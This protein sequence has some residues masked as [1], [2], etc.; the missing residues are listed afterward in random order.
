[1]S[2][3]Q[4]SRQ[5]SVLELHRLRKTFKVGRGPK[6]RKVRAVDDVSLTLDKGTTLAVVGES[7]SGKTTLARLAMSLLPPDDGD[8]LLNGRN[9]TGLSPRALA[10][11]RPSMQ[12]VFQDPFDSLAPWHTAEQIVGSS[13]HLR[14]DLG[15]AERRRL[16]VEVLE[17]VGLPQRFLSRY[18]HELSGGQAQRVG[19]ARAIVTRP[20]LVVLDEPT[21]ALD[22]SV[23]AQILALLHEL[24]NEEQLSYLFISHDLAVVRYLA[25]RTAVMRRG[26]SWRSGTPPRSSIGPRTTTPGSSWRRHPGSPRRQAGGSPTE[27][28]RMA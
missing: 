25:D 3:G 13:L 1:M 6:A 9:L 15:P 11:F 12:M 2:A 18:P 4:S 10:R 17:R 5:P 20:S 26:R 7:G 14:R 27:P 19:I 16:V 21:S 28:E 23:Q 24:Q 22:M 8:I